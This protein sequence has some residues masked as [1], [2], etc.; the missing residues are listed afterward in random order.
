MGSRARALLILGSSLAVSG[1]LF[2]S[3][4]Q[5]DRAKELFDQAFGAEGPDFEKLREGVALWQELA[6]EDP[7]AMYYLG[8]VYMSGFD[9]ILER[10]EARGLALT[11]E[12]ADK[13]FLPAQF[14]LAWQHESG[15]YRPRNLQ[16]ALALYEQAAAGGYVFAISRLIRV[17]SEGE[18]G[19]APDESKANYW[20]ARH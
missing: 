1:A 14:A 12:A 7:G 9:G 2:P 19:V 6:S 4:A 8:F 13:G 18:L 5:S 10:D 11:E 3:D 16:K 17:Y 20:R 15:T